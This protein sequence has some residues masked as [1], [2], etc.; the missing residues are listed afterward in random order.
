VPAA[1]AP[2]YYRNRFPQKNF[3]AFRLQGT[4]SNRDAIGAVVRLYVGGEVLTRQ[5]NP[6][7]GYL[8]QSSKTVHFGLGDRSRI[9]RVEIRWPGAADPVDAPNQSAER[10]RRT[11][12]LAPK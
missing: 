11:G 9:D 1:Q 3:I 7:G 4:K 2:F 8:S 12:E 5:V 6:D 10:S